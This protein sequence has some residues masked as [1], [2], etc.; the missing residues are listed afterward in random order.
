MRMKYVISLWQL[1]DVWV[2]DD[3]WPFN[4]ASS[5]SDEIEL[6]IAL[7]GMIVCFS[8]AFII[9]VYLILKSRKQKK[10]TKNSSLD[11]EQSKGL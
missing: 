3:P 4:L 2:P 11:Q 5:S 1:L 7:V 8:I 10:L 6:V 9:V